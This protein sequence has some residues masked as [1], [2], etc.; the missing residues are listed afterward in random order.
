MTRAHEVTVFERRA[1]SLDDIRVQCRAI[2]ER[3]GEAIHVEA[4][5]LRRLARRKTWAVA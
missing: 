2:R 4:V 3:T 1:R 5:P